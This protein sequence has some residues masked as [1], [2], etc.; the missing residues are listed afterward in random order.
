M[1]DQCSKALSWR[2]RS[3]SIGGLGGHEQVEHFVRII[4]EA[5]AICVWMQRILWVIE[6]VAYGRKLEEVH[7]GETRLNV[8]DG[9]VI[10]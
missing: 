10:V 6:W 5:K 1:S 2:N 7:P 8:T 3:S 4:L 9:Y